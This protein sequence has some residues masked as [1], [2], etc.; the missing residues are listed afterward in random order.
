M[1]NGAI[2][3]SSATTSVKRSFSIPNQYFQT[4]KF[5]HQCSWKTIPDHDA[6]TLDWL[7]GHYSPI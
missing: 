7:F 4:E 1:V 6:E 5:N 3:V 2:R